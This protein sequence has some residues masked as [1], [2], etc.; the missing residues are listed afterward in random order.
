MSSL[1]HEK[2]FTTSFNVDQTPQQVFSAI[3]NVRGWW[4]EEIEGSTYKLGEE[5][6]YHFQDVHRCTMKI[7]ELVPDK[8]IVW[9]VLDNYFSFTHDKSEWKGTQ[10]VFEIAKSGD[11]TEVRFTHLGLVTEYECYNA[12][13]EGWSSYINGSLKD[14]ITTGKGQPNVGG[15][16]TE[17]ERAL[18]SQDYTTTFTVNQTPQQVF[19]AIN[20]VRGWWTGEIAGNTNKLGDEFTYRF[21]EFHYSK[22][23]ITEWIPDKKVVWLVSEAS[24]NFVKDKAEWNGTEITFAITKKG[25]KT[26]V[27]FTHTGLV[28]GIQCYDACSDAWGG[29]ING[30]LRDLITT[31]KGWP[32]Q[33]R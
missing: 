14:L 31:G 23:K 25:D 19:S 11:K 24:L 4:S 18:A 17:S 22:H 26:E 21:K 29:Y 32:N 1:H 20:N 2:S 6:K 16:I 15:A 28:P 3:N 9:H 8:R 30:S 10:I 33:Q 12:C 7:T 5:F 27:R 13:S